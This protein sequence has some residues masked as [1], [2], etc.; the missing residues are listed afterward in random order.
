MFQPKF[1]F[2]FEKMARKWPKLGSGAYF[3]V[4]W[5]F[6]AQNAKI[7]K[8]KFFAKYS[9]VTSLTR[10]GLYVYFFVFRAQE[11]YLALHA[12]QICQ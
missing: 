6:E 9:A 11:A 8:N 7:S 12:P 1:G 2:E 5:R 3:W 10:F 4:K